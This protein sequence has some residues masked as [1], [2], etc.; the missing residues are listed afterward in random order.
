MAHGA[1]N[2]PCYR[3]SLSCSLQFR[4]GSAQCRCRRQLSTAQ[5]TTHN[6]QALSEHHP[7]ESLP[8]L[9]QRF[10]ASAVVGPPFF[11][12]GV[13]ELLQV[14]L[15]R[16]VCC[17]SATPR[18]PNRRCGSRPD[19]P[20]VFILR[21]LCPSAQTAEELEAVQGLSLEVRTARASASC[22][23]GVETPRPTALQARW[24]IAVAPVAWRV[25]GC[26][27]ALLRYARA[28]A[29]GTP[30]PLGPTSVREA[31]AGGGAGEA[32]TPPAPEA[33]L[34][35]GAASPERVA[36]L[37]AEHQALGLYLWLA[38]RLGRDAFPDT[39]A[40]ETRQADLIRQLDAGLEQLDASAGRASG[41]GQGG[42]GGGAPWRGRGWDGTRS[43]WRG[44]EEEESRPTAAQ[45]LSWTTVRALRRRAAVASST[46]A[47]PPVG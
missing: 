16:T 25:P 22:L 15:G 37:E 21:G 7:G 11:L 5:P 18:Q 26:G 6:P 36:L 4:P 20:H 35:S 14:C 43:R 29:D 31:A 27:E 45:S 1:G 19:C 39:E 2:R 30:V 44:A 40:A 9:L 17:A 13:G 12:C 46:M 38:L 23:T 42:R 33:A 24:Q 8:Q 3:Y 32:Q 10:A 28:Y 41:T 34:G 47:V